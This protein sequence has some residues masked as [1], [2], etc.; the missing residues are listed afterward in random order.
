MTSKYPT[1]RNGSLTSPLARLIPRVIRWEQIHQEACVAIEKAVNPTIA[2]EPVLD[3][4]SPNVMAQR[5]AGTPL[6][7]SADVD[8]GSFDISL[9]SARLMNCTLRYQRLC[10]NDE[11]QHLDMML[12]K[13]GSPP[14]ARLPLALAGRHR[15]PL[16]GEAMSF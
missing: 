5:T 11:Q 1:N 10:S 2:I 6:T 9:D 7:G 12:A 8:N 13:V 3:R 4:V 15:E 14:A 16:R